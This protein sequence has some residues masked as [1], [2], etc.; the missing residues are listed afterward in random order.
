LRLLV[1]ALVASAAV[2]LGCNGGRSADG[3]GDSQ[4][5]AASTLEAASGTAIVTGSVPGAATTP[6]YV[7][8]TPE[9]D[10]PGDAPDTRPVMDQVQMTFVPSM[11]FARTGHPVEFRSSDEELHNVNVKRS[12]TFE[13]EFNVAIPP[14]GTFEHTF[15]NPGFYDLNCD[16]HP[17]MSAQILVASTPHVAVAGQDGSFAF[18][19]VEPGDYTLTVYAGARRLEQGLKV[20]P[21][22]NSVFLASDGSE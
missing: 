4:P 13:Q 19:D 1:A 9:R 15:K 5:G 3:P 20:S 11:L 10:E 21:G 7:V 2:S 14:G 22:Q 12:R 18:H 6:A 17:A 8:L 16:I